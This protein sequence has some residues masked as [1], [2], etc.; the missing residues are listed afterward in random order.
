MPRCN[1]VAPW[2]EHCKEQCWWLM[3]P[4]CN[5]VAPWF[6]HGQRPMVWR[7]KAYQKV[8]KRTNER[9]NCAPAQTVVPGP[10]WLLMQLVVH[11]TLVHYPSVVWWCLRYIAEPGS[12]VPHT[13]NCGSGTVWA[14]KKTNQRNQ[15]ELHHSLQSCRRKRKIPTVTSLVSRS[16][17]CSLV[18]PYSSARILS[19]MYCW[20]RWQC[21]SMCLELF[22]NTGFSVI[23]R[24]A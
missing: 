14:D 3:M 13:H 22:R 19:S 12:R 15:C 4:R 24:A 18:G 17:A 8:S 10:N 23:A 16:A 20:T 7:N 5:I 21:V 2:F 11:Q 6:G 1:I 9:T